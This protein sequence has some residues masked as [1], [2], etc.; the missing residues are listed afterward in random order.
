MNWPPWKRNEPVK[1]AP[2]RASC[3]E[4]LEK[5]LWGI[6]K[7]P[8]PVALKDKLRE[9]VLEQEDDWKEVLGNLTYAAPEQRM[10]WDVASK[11]MD[12]YNPLLENAGIPMEY[13]RDLDRHIAQA[14]GGEGSFAF[15]IRVDYRS[16]PYD[17]PGK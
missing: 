17:S 1:P 12:Q 11:F 6:E 14:L 8:L 9:R 15:E 7:S 4:K 3:P 5:L 2:A 10:H 13:R 16:S